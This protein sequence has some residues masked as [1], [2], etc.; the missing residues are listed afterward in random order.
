MGAMMS[1]DLAA[2]ELQPD[3][4]AVPLAL[5]QLQAI[6]KSAYA[7]MKETALA[8]SMG[9]GARTR[10]TSVLNADSIEPPPIM[11]A[12]M[13]AGKYYELIAQSIMA[14]QD[15]EGSENPLSV[16]A[17]IALRDAMITIGEIYDRMAFNVHF[18]QRG[19][20]LETNIT[21]SE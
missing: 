1:P 8:V 4:V 13:D 5:P 20:E 17:R 6:A 15:E 16:S 14:E 2:V 19:V 7:A 3:G 11:S 9:S 21:M 10:V 18:T 12:S